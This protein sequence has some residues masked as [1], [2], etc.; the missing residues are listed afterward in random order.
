MITATPSRQLSA[1][2]IAP[3]TCESRMSRWDYRMVQSSDGSDSIIAE[4]YYG[5]T[6]LRWV[7]DSR[8]CLRW[9]TYEDL[10]A[11]VDMI[12]QALDKP[13][14]RVVDGDRLVEV[15]PS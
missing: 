7:N 14:L 8:Q 10:K 6:G 13:L 2:V 3:G 11:R 1:P 5:R 15:A 4:V 9:N 12:R